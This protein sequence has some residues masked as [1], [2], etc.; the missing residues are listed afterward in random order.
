[1]CP[2]PVLTACPSQLL[3]G[4]SSLRTTPKISLAYNNNRLLFSSCYTP[5]WVCWSSAGLCSTLF[6]ILAFQ[7][8]RIPHLGHI[9]RVIFLWSKIVVLSWRL[10]C[11]QIQVWLEV[12]VCREDV[13]TSESSYS[14]LL[15]LEDNFSKPLMTEINFLSG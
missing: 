12:H 4:H 7:L 5:L 6:F 2:R 1:M 10:F 15:V 3:L 11:A 8:K 9:R 14:S 13:C